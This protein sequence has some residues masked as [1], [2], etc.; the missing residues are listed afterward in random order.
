ML[1][2][3]ERASN[4]TP[5]VTYTRGADISGERQNA[6]GIG[7]LLARTDPVGS[8]LYHADGN[9]NITMLVNNTGAI[10]AK[11]LYDPYGNTLGA[12]GMLADAN[13]YR[14]SSMET[15]DP[16][17]A[18]LYA[19]RVY[20]PNLQHWAQRDPIGELGGLNS[21]GFVGNNPLSHVDMLGL[22]FQIGPFGFGKP[23]T[24]I[25]PNGGNHYDTPPS[26]RNNNGDDDDESRFDKNGNN[27][28]Y[29][30]GGSR[31][32]KDQCEKAGKDVK[33]VGEQAGMILASGITGPE[34]EMAELGDATD[35]ADAA[36]GLSK[37]ETADPGGL[38]LF[39]WKHPTSIKDKDWKDGDY[40]L[41]LPNQ[42]TPQKNWLQN[43]GRLRD[44]MNKGNPIYDSYRDVGGQLIPAK[45][46]LN[47]ERNLLQNRGWVYNPAK[48]A[49]Y[50]PK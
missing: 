23:P 27:G 11:Y 43:S 22:Y 6:G 47:A 37:C 39:K 30:Y 24:W 26:Q 12:W 41:Y 33:F 5:L 49:W 15:Y 20:F 16:A 31:M 2:I 35:A 42:G 44:E 28:N 29:S 8:A 7:G 38:N 50:P 45:G 13:N 34:S 14:F 48:G 40:F 18:V 46:F 3:Q 25:D 4:N 19:Y 21:Y 1:V 17:G 36:Q 32:T 9:G 10:L